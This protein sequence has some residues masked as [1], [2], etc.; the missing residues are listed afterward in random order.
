MDMCRGG[1]LREGERG[2]ACV[3]GRCGTGIGRWRY[4]DSKVDIYIYIYI[5]IC[6][7]IYI[8]VYVC[9]SGVASNVTFVLANVW[10]QLVR[11]PATTKTKTSKE[12][13]MLSGSCDN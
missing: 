13:P 7:H 8:H 11:P 10:S 6:I 1:A 3:V 2:H 9:M 12:V 5:Y 4:Y